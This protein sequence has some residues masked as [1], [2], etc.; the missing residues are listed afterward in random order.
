[1]ARI[2]FPGRSIV[3]QQVQRALGGLK[4]DGD[5]RRSTWQAIS[6]RL[7]IPVPLIHASASVQFPDRDSITKRVQSALGGILIDGHDGQETWSRLAERFDPALRDP[8]MPTPPVQPPAQSGRYSERVV[9]SPNRNAGGNRKLGA[10]LHHASGY[11]DGTV[12][13]C[14]NPASKVSY[15]VLINTD[16]SRTAMVP[17]DDR[18]WHAGVSSWR[19]MSGCNGFT[20]GI[21]YIGNTNDGAMRGQAGRDLT[22]AEIASTLEWL[23]PRMTRYGWTKSDLTAHRLISPGRKDDTSVT[24]LQQILAAL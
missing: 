4:V 20:L 24:A 13:W 23:R 15:H 3:V 18:A 22:A 8:T 17:D 10:V 5:D 19:G 7:L 21:A 11:Y 14:L 9:K 6:N 12:S 1:M 2:P 16:G